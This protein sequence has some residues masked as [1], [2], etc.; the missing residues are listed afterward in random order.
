MKIAVVI[1]TYNEKDTLPS[2]IEN[3]FEK[4]KPVVDELHLVIVDDSSPDG[5]ADLARNIA[6]KFE[7]ITVIQRPT[8]AGL[9]AAYKH[10]FNHVL[11]N[12][13]SN[14]IVQM[15]ADNSHEPSEIT[16]MIE[17]I[18]DYDFVI[19]SRHVPGSSIIGWGLG[20]QIIH[21]VAGGIAKICTKI[22][23]E[24]STSGFRMFKRETLEQ[25][26]FD[27]IESDGF[28]FQIEVLYKLKQKGLRGLEL[29]TT[30]VNRIKGESKM[31]RSEIVQFTKMCL[32]YIGNKK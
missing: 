22:D 32:S 10:G 6:E 12:L 1:P 19:A 13:E 11:D 3:L 16:I 2:L 26:E 31:G 15:D 8:K 28:A 14:L 30:F 4:I 20:R 24:D 21:S 18:S 25:I 23:I 5:T 7:K 17:K 27:S 29:P 9:G